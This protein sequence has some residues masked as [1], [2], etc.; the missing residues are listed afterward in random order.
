MEI[1]ITSIIPKMSEAAFKKN[2][3]AVG[4]SK[5]VIVSSRSVLLYG[6]LKARPERA[7]ALKEFAKLFEKYGA[8]YSK[9]PNGSKP[10]PGFVT[11]GSTKFELKPES[12]AGSVILKPGLFGTTVNKVVDVDIPYASYTAK[13]LSSIDQTSKL[14]DVQKDF[15]R[16]LVEYTASPSPTTKAKIGKLLMGGMT[17]LQLN[18][19]NN[20]F[21]EVL[22]PIA[23]MTK[24][25]L[26][27]DRK[28]AVVRI[29]ARSNEPLLD[30]KISD[31]T[32]EYKISAK[33]GETT[34]TLKPGDV[35]SLIKGDKKLIKKWQ[36][37]PEFKLIEI[38]DEGSTKQGPI[39]A[40]MWLKKNGYKTYFD[41]LKSDDYTEEVRQKCEDTIVKISREA[42]D[43]TPIFADA[44]N[45][46]VFYVKFK[47]S[48]SGDM[49]WKLV[50]TPKDK[51]NDAA[52]RKRITFRSKNYV[53]RPGDKLG[54]Q[55]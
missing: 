38:L 6:P 18:T 28:S 33:S 48:N 14:T 30:Y 5:Y 32:R 47:L 52:T 37:T 27:I 23:V 13:L 54:F 8:R 36:N 22:G 53:G 42:M 43:L 46:K 7:E 11:I 45:T 15:L 40:G 24:G 17:G 9:A 26:P 34:N 39:T 35:A 1:K 31:K 25:F 29:P 44:T 3:T 21:G 2:L 4:M 55:V 49:E 19:I 20:D 51:K 10:S 50:E 41:W 16:M 12:T